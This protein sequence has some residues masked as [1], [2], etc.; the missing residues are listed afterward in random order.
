[1][2]GFSKCKFAIEAWNWIDCFDAVS[3]MA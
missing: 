1:M 2:F 3:K